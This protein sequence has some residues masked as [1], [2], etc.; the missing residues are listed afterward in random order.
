M[1]TLNGEQVNVTL[2]PDGTSQVWNIPLDT[3]SKHVNSRIF[4]IDWNFSHEGELF[5]LCQLVDLLKTIKPNY[6]ISL[7]MDFL[8]YSRQDKVVS[9][10]TTFALTTFAKIINSLKL[11]RVST[12]DVHS[13]A[14][15]FLLNNFRN[16]FPYT[17][18]A[19][20]FREVQPD[21]ICFPDKGALSRYGKE[22]AFLGKT[23]VWG[24]KVR[25]QSTGH[26]VK[27]TLQG[28][29]YKQK[30]LIVDDICDGG[31]TFIMMAKALLTAGASSV[32]L[33][34]S[35]GIYSK[36]LRP[37]REAKIE[38]IFTKDGEVGELQGQITIQPFKE[39]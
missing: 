25:D 30:V 19:A 13:D 29:V 10:N 1:L 35:H 2:F 4:I 12:I 20:A 3:L 28:D 34:T 5:Q 27:C 14:A 32:N 21:V 39:I 37:L 26:I 23:Y 22:L 18:V 11:D 8:P 24:E 9:N 16:D 31:M 36:G 33:Y 15:M 17:H 38:R 6:Q 7:N